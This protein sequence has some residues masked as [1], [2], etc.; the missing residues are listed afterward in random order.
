MIW[1]N[2]QTSSGRLGTRTNRLLVENLSL[3]MVS[4]EL[5]VGL[6]SSPSQQSY[7]FWWKMNCLFFSFVLNLSSAQL[8]TMAIFKIAYISTI[9]IYAYFK[10]LTK[11]FVSYLSRLDMF[12]SLCMPHAKDQH[13]N[14]MSSVLNEWDIRNNNNVNHTR[15]HR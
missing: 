4:R 3:S 9:Y 5:I 8:K 2:D 12:C 1:R 7:L 10:V 13:M 6:M 15:S 14:V 11:M